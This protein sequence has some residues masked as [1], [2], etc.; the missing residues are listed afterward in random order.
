MVLSTAVCAC[1]YANI[2]LHPDDK[3]IA[4]ERGSRGYFKHHSYGR[5][6]HLL[7]PLTSYMVMSRQQFISDKTTSYHRKTTNKYG[8]RRALS[9]SKLLRDQTAE[10]GTSHYGILATTPLGTPLSSTC[11]D[12]TF[13][14]SSKQYLHRPHL[15]TLL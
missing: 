12:H 2:S 1:K 4:K 14:H 10:V 11:I 3:Q 15:W 9:L 6:I 7:H 8:T 13:G 5:Q